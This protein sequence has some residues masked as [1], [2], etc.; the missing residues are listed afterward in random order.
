LQVVAPETAHVFY[1]NPDYLTRFNVGKHRLEPLALERDP[2]N[3]IVH[4]VTSCCVTVFLAIAIQN[5]FLHRY[6]VALTFQLV[7]V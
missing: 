5:L 1:E 6:A 4:I 3:T 2:G 7:I